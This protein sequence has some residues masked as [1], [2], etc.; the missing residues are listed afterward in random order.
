MAPKLIRVLIVDDSPLIRSLLTRGLARHGDIEVVGQ[1][2]DGAEAVQQIQ[3]LR[4]DVVTLDIEM[5]RLN[6][7]QVLDQLVGRVPVRFIMVSTLTQAGA[8]VT[9]EA[10]R[11]G[12]VDYIPK[13]QADTRTAL[14]DFQ[15]ELIRKVRAAA[16]ARLR[17]PPPAAA[18][19]AP[20]EG[21]CDRLIAI[22]ISCGGPPTLHRVLPAF[23]PSFPPVLITQHMPP[24]FTGP[25]ARHLDAACRMRVREATQHEPLSPGTIYIAP[26]DRHLKVIGRP[27]AWRAE[28][29][30]GPPVSGHRPSVDAMFSALAQTCGRWTIGVVMTG[31]G[32]DGAVGLIALKRSGAVTLAQDEASSY[33]Y[34]MPRAAFETGCVDRVFSESELPELLAHLLRGG[35]VPAAR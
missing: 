4:P 7:L 24:E 25:F 27:G 20:P 6:G 33:I 21:V 1:A 10:L 8:K 34:G 16:R 13:P 2:G 29:D 28:L 22:G 14:P 30:S 12:A 15:E 5:P 19:V 35:R 17:P 23:P 9:F 31:M 26:G 3:L 11:K 32:R 18:P